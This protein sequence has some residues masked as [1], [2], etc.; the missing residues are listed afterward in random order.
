M[1]LRI[2][3]L[4]FTFLSTS[5]LF[6]QSKF[7][8]QFDDIEKLANS[9]QF[10]LAD[11]LLRPILPLVEKESSK[12]EYIEVLEYLA[13][14]SYRLTRVEEADSLYR[15]V[16]EE[17][18][19]FYG[20]NSSNYS[21]TLSDYSEFK[22]YIQ[23]YDDLEKIFDELES[24]VATL[25]GTKS[26]EFGKILANKG[27]LYLS[28]NQYPKAFAT[29]MK[30]SKLLKDSD[31]FRAKLEFEI[32]TYYYQ[33]QDLSKAEEYYLK[34]RIIY[35]SIYG[36]K[37][38]DYAAC[39][40][41][42]SNIRGNL[43]EYHEA[44]ELIEEYMSIIENCYGKNNLEYAKALSNLG[45]FLCMKKSYTEAEKNFKESLTISKQIVG[46]E[47]YVYFNAL[48]GLAGLYLDV[49]MYDLAESLLL[50]SLELRERLYGTQNTSYAS[51]LISLGNLYANIGNNSE[52]L[53]I[54]FRA[55]DIL[56]A[57]IGT[58]NQYYGICLSSIGSVYS[59]QQNFDEAILYY[60]ESLNVLKTLGENNE[61]LLSVT[62]EIAYLVDKILPKEK[63]QVEKI[64]ITVCKRKEKINSK[65]YLRSLHS[66]A[67]FYG[68]NDRN[69]EALDLHLI[70]DRKIDE[71]NELYFMNLFN[72][73]HNY[74]VLKNYTI[75]YHYYRKAYDFF[76]NDFLNKFIYFTDNQR[77]LFWHTSNYFLDS[78]YLFCHDYCIQNP[79]VASDLYNSS[80]FSKSLLLNSSLLIKQEIIRNGYEEKWNMLKLM[81]NEILSNQIYSANKGKEQ[82]NA[83]LNKDRQ[84]EFSLI[85]KFN[86]MEKELLASSVNLTTIKEDYLTE[87]QDIERKLN[88]DELA[89]EFIKFSD[90][91]SQ[92][93]KYGA[94]L[95]Q[96]HSR[97]IYIPLCT[98]EKLMEAINK[99]SF[100]F[101]EVYPYIWKPLE[102]YLDKITTIY[103]SPTGLL[104]TISFNGMCNNEHYLIDKHE[105]INFL[106]TKNILKGSPKTIDLKQ[107]YTLL[108]GSPDFSTQIS[109]KDN[110]PSLPPEII[111][112]YRASRSQ[113]FDYLPGVEKELRGIYH[114]LKRN[115]C[116]TDL[117]VDKDANELLF[118]E[119]LL[120]KPLLL[121]ISSHGFYLK[122]SNKWNP[123]TYDYVFENPLYRSGIALAGANQIWKGKQIFSSQNDGIL[124]AFELSNMNLNE[125]QL[126]ILSACE[127]GLGD[128]IGSEGV[129]GLYRALKIAGVNQIIAG[130]WNLPDTE[131]SELIEQLYINILSGQ[132]VNTSLRNAQKVLRIKYPRSPE[133][134][135]GLMLIE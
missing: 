15:Q 96:K 25:N 117:L 123:N 121:H 41:A 109:S 81:R 46:R 66:L 126:V 106:S 31:V 78:Y 49:R 4:S 122:V 76:K 26:K 38:P 42:L 7:K 100:D 98:E 51:A 118:A 34:S 65:T 59:S 124:T 58:K 47:H 44:K 87:W 16:L 125:T 116:S 101:K 113:G 27:N 10:A 77:E 56:K 61:D 70:I 79:E 3:L 94:L 75:A 107:N 6:S 29:F 30:A 8:Q 92:E 24:I 99:S 17:K 22:L 90:I 32:G 67:Y 35:K 120:K 28:T 84:D 62:E 74:H 88:V 86:S 104:N 83:S 1:L 45:V 68:I 80:L 93:V 134:W 9:G 50:E 14:L 102:K 19:I 133:K 132:T 119:R 128:I 71:N 43:K 95:L 5:F 110:S 63:D 108:V 73:A 131:T 20:K 112:A 48:H 60:E 54:L 2:I 103:I 85:M 91:T 97:P 130:L 127:T 57:T 36:N 72:I 69:L 114:L 129:F 64:L 11:S 53:K 55:R 115:N 111:N 135:A 12:E 89:I 37:H 39:L 13:S 52:S 21:S 82:L 105:I 23:A 40:L 18:I 33:T